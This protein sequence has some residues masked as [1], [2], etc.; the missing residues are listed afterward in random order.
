[1]KTPE[2]GTYQLEFDV[3][4][5]LEKSL[6]TSSLKRRDKKN[7]STCNLNTRYPQIQKTLENRYRFQGF[8]FGQNSIFI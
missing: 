2:S 8:Y 5:A 7:I 6:K 3:C 4:L 1:M